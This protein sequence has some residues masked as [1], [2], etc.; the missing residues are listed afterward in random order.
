MGH[1]RLRDLLL[2]GTRFPHPVAL[3][4][5]GLDQRRLDLALRRLRHAVDQRPIDLPHRAGLEGAAELG[6]DRAALG[7]HQ[8]PR[9]VAVEPVHEP[10]PRLRPVAQAFEQAVDVMWRFGP[11][12]HRDSRRLVEDEKIVI[13]VERAGGKEVAVGLRQAMSRR[14]RRR[15]Y[16]GAAARALSDR[17]TSRVLDLAR[18]PSTLTCPVRNS[19]SSR[20]WGRLA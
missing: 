16:R 6:R 5:C 17:R 13:L 15:R 11:A 9:G 10:R 4:S 18:A 12:L 3:R 19:F 1:R 8:H 20:L 14:R 2:A 7:H